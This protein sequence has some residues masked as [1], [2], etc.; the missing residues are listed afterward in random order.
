MA[1]LL[2]NDSENTNGVDADVPP[3]VYDMVGKMTQTEQS[4]FWYQY[5]WSINT[6]LYLPMKAVA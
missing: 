6:A 3:V 4:L 5:L 2:L 1:N